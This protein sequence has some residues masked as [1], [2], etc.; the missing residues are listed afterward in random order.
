[1][2]IISAEITPVDMNNFVY[3]SSINAVFEDGTKATVLSFYPDEV[4][5]TA[6]EV[7]GKT[8]GEVR[9]LFLDKDRAYLL[10]P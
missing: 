6:E 9:Q 7:V 4:R 1:M 8:E 2:K 10:S 5:F 3:R